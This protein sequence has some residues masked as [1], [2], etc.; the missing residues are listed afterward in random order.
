MPN[1]TDVD[2]FAIP[3][4]FALGE[5][6]KRF[7]NPKGENEKI[8][9]ESLRRSRDMWKNIRING[10]EICG[11]TYE[12]FCEQPNRKSNVLFLTDE[13]MQKYRKALKIMD[14]L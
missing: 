11:M 2:I 12:E 8:I 1:K 3:I 14:L 6:I 9:Y 13:E 10:L 4:D 5:T 7:E